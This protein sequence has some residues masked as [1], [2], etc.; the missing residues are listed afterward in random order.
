MNVY[1]LQ[2]THFSVTGRIME[3][4]TYLIGPGGAQEHALRLVNM[5]REEV[6]LPHGEDPEKFEHYMLEARDKRAADLGLPSAE[7][8]H[9]DDDAAV[10]ITER[11]LRGVGSSVCLTA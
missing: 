5:A 2:G 7:S 9:D 3:V 8:L 6:D 10:W 11:Q 1:I 4:F